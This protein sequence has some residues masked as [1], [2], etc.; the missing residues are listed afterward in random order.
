LLQTQLA[1]S[2]TRAQHLGKERAKANQE[3]A[4]LARLME[5]SKQSSALLKSTIDSLPQ[6]IFCKEINGAYAFANKAF[7]ETLNVPFDDVAGRTE[8]D[9]FSLDAA[10]ANLAYDK[11]ALETA[12]TLESLLIDDFGGKKL[13]AQMTRAPRYDSDGNIAGTAGIFWEVADNTRVE[14]ALARERDLLNALMDSST[15]VIYFKD[16]ESRFL[17]INKAHAALFG[18]SD[19]A[20]AVGKRD[21]DFFTVEHAQAAYD[22]EQRIIQTGTPLVGVEERETWPDKEDTWASTTKHPLFDRNGQI[23]GTFGITRDITERK[24]AAEALDRS[25]AAFEAFVSQVSEGNLT[26]RSREGDDTLGRVSQSINKMLVSFSA[27]ITGVKS[28]GLSLSASAN[29]MLAAAEEIA[30]GSQEQTNETSNVTSSVEEMAASMEQVSKNAEASAEAARQALEKADKGTQ[31][32][33]DTSEAMIKINDAVGRTADKMRLLAQRSSEITEIM[34]LINGIAAQT[35]LLALNAAI[36]AAHAGEAGL[37]FSVVAEEIRKLADKSVQA[38]RDVGELI[39]GIQSET[40]AAISAMENGMKEV[41]DGLVLAEHSR[42]A[43]LDIAS[44]LERS[45][46]LAEEISVASEQQTRVTLNLAAAM[47]TI[48]S[49]T[50]Q[51]SA[52]AHETTQIINGMVDL[53]EK[54]NQSISQ[55]KVRDGLT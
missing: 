51:A 30:K 19:P 23:I 48:S 40:A 3:L 36:E 1:Q 39:K 43:L 31:S 52:A 2:E 7:R 29:Q 34:G 4:E 32:V 46:E 35:N 28:L 6:G 5:E 54:L 16:R 25:L 15:D 47:Q 41:K 8:T 13:Y 38:T 17:R 24:R 33:R 44:G 49:I 18:L 55:F 11:K 21:F 37:G 53:S 27:M 45:T 26:V 42:Q 12:E 50:M 14:E 10:T 9:F 22:D 20:E